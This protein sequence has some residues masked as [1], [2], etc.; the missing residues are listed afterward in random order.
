MPDEGF[1]ELAGPRVTLRRFHPGDVTEFVAYR[2]CE[3][4][5]R[6]QSWDAPYPRDEGERF[7]QQLAKEHPDT[8][9][10]WFQFAVALRPAGQLI[11]D[12]AAIPHADDPRQCEVGFM[13]APQRRSPWPCREVAEV[14]GTV[15]HIPR[16]AGLSSLAASRRAGEEQ[17]L[18][19]VGEVVAEVLR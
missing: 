3:Q 16:R 8:A 6:F 18:P 2:S 15:W 19:G 9:G 10:E 12:C 7:I 13:I 17:P 4:V 1:T 11:G 5:A 14:V